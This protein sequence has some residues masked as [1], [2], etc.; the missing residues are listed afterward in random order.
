MTFPFLRKPVTP[1]TNRPD[2]PGTLPNPKTPFSPNQSLSEGNRQG[3]SPTKQ[4]ELPPLSE[5]APGGNGNWAGSKIFE[6]PNSP[7]IEFTI[8][9]AGGRLSGAT[10]PSWTR[11]GGSQIK[12]DNPQSRALDALVKKM[13]ETGETKVRLTIIPLAIGSRGMNA[14]NL[15]TPDKLDYYPIRDHY[16]PDR[17]EREYMSLTPDHSYIKLTLMLRDSEPVIEITIRIRIQADGD[18]NMTGSAPERYANFRKRVTPGLAV[19]NVLKY[20]SL[21]NLH[22]EVQ[23]VSHMEAALQRLSNSN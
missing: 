4:F 11:D 1:P 12:S 2:Q 18:E 6:K 16:T 9:L 19:E 21:H 14:E 13:L 15:I 8:P 20:A 5:D 10:E 22:V 23:L 7:P 3:N 17:M